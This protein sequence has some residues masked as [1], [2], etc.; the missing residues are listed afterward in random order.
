MYVKLKEEYVNTKAWESFAKDEGL[1][2]SLPFEVGDGGY[3]YT[4][5]GWLIPFSAITLISPL[6]DKSLE[7]YL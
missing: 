6:L 4:Y 7:D 2:L 3:G 5:K 1:D